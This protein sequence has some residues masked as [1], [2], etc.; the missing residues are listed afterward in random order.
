[1]QVP[2][3]IAFEQLLQVAPDYEL[4]VPVEELRYSPSYFLRGL[5]SLP[6]VPAGVTAL[7]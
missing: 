6:V 7:R 5:E 1:M 2:L 4:A 3:Q